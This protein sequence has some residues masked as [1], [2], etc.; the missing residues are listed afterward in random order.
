MSSPCS[1]VAIHLSTAYRSRRQERWLT[2]GSDPTGQIIPLRGP[3]G[4]CQL[5]HSGPEN[6]FSQIS[7]VSHARVRSCSCPGS[8]PTGAP[9]GA[10]TDAALDHDEVSAAVRLSR[11]RLPG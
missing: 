4:A 9:D 6:A 3:F 1:F 5:V 7:R 10:R 2:T 11:Q 8:R